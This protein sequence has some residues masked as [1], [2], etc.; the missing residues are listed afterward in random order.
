MLWLNIQTSPTLLKIA[1]KSIDFLEIF[2]I[3]YVFAGVHIEFVHQVKKT[4]IDFI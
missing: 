3:V 4:F 2:S 1:L